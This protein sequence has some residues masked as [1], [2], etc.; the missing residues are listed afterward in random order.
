MTDLKEDFRIW[1][2]ENSRRLLQVAFRHS[3]N[4][5][6][7]EDVYQTTLEKF[8]ARWDN[9]EFRKRVKSDPGFAPRCVIN[10]WRD[11]ARSEIADRERLKKTMT[12]KV[13]DEA[14]SDIER[15]EMISQ[16]LGE[17]DPTWRSVIELRYMQ[18]KSITETAAALGISEATAR[19][20]EKRAL[21]ALE[22]AEQRMGDEWRPR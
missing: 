10:N 1:C 18:E 12:G 9:D 11:L 16:M 17:L 7:A 6:T 5:W 4:R 20:Y 19:R 8:W 2:L 13:P 3:R 14:Y 22:K 21:A 15:D